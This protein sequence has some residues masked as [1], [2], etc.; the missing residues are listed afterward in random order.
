[1]RPAILWLDTRA[2]AEIAA[3]GDDRV[4]ETT[5]K[6]PNT[7]TSWYKLLWLQEHEPAA[8]ARTR[9]VADVQA[10]LVHRM[11]GQWR[12]SFGSVDPTG[13]LDL[14]GF[15]L[16]ADL[17]RRA[18]V[19]LHRAKVTGRARSCVADPAVPASAAPRQP[20]RLPARSA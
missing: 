8:M 19:A 4:H 11:T 13:L 14:R 15:A 7:A 16:D 10:Y 20:E 12:T 2:T 6:P 3:H 1:M 17:L 9:W 5:G 18:G